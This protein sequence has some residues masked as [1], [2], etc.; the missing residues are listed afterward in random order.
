MAAAL[1]GRYGR[2]DVLGTTTRDVGRALARERNREET[3]VALTD[4]QK[5]RIMS[6]AQT[7]K[8]R[9][10][11]TELFWVMMELVATEDAS[12]ILGMLKESADDVD[13][14]H[15]C[16]LCGG[17]RCGGGGTGGGTQHCQGCRGC[18]RRTRFCQPHRDGCSP[19]VCECSQ[20]PPAWPPRLAKYDAL[21][22][23]FAASGAN[24]VDK[25]FGWNIGMHAAAQ[26]KV[27]TLR[28]LL[29]IRDWDGR[30]ATERAVLG[31]GSADS[32]GT[33]LEVSGWNPRD[34][35]TST[36]TEE[37]YR[38]KTTSVFPGSSN[39]TGEA[40]EEGLTSYP[41]DLSVRSRETRTIKHA[42]WWKAGADADSNRS[43]RKPEKRSVERLLEE[44]YG[45]IDD[46]MGSRLIDIAEARSTRSLKST[47]L[48]TTAA[49][50]CNSDLKNA[51]PV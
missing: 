33:A 30:D 34:P 5:D 51:S 13:P 28:M 18:V 1:P 25:H 8:A 11:H 29:N 24:L 9:V 10:V 14:D 27:E 2:T 41:L 21:R 20:H 22:P 49:C 40:P 50:R 3:G 7:A 16:S 15:R 35:V 23:G 4:R 19:G 46:P 48:A 39:G 32:R 17:E 38:I 42:F 6:R 47:A 37:T 26:G 12:T 43:L 45:R 31:G 44:A 36:L